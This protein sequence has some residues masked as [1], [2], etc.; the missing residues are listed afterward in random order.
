MWYRGLLVPMALHRLGRHELRPNQHRS[1]WIDVAI[2]VNRLERSSLDP[3]E[4][5]A[6]QDDLDFDQFQLDCV[7]SLVRDNPLVTKRVKERRKESLMFS[8][9]EEDV[10][11]AL[12][13]M[14]R[15]N[16]NGKKPAESKPRTSVA[17]SPDS[18]TGSLSDATAAPGMYFL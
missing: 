7:Y 16:H 17:T 6:I 3:K 1:A 18:T 12:Q 9:K 8:V 2:E 11:E 10:R 13:N 15:R 4:A 14:R 5:W